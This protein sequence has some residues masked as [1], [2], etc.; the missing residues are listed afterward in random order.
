MDI[1]VGQVGEEIV[2][3]EDGEKDE[4]VYDTL[5]IIRKRKRVFNSAKFE[6]EVLAHQ[7]KV[8][9]VEVNGFETAKLSLVSKYEGEK[10]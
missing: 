10:L 7:G 4:V 6:V 1:E 2:S 8:K 9:E 5:D 3:N